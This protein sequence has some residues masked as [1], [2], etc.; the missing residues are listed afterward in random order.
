[1]SKQDFDSLKIILIYNGFVN[2]GNNVFESKCRVWKIA[3]K[4]LDVFVYESGALYLA[5]FPYLE[6]IPEVDDK[7][8]TAK[9]IKVLGTLIVNLKIP[10]G[11]IIL[12]LP[13]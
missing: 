1:M 3:I 2:L 9:I 10:Q 6:D 11:K 7:L 8:D 5:I 4:S 12:R 13:E